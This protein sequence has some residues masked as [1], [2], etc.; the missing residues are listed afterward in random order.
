MRKLKCSITQLIPRLG[1]LF[2]AEKELIGFYL[3]RKGFNID[4]EEFAKT[5]LDTLIKED[6]LIGMLGF[7]SVENN[8]QDSDYATSVTKERRK[9]IQ[10]TKGFRFVF[11]KGSCFQNEL[12]KLDGSEN[13]EFIPVFK[14]G[15][16]L[17]AQNKD[18]SIKGFDSRLFIGIKQLQVSADVAGST[19]EVDITPRGMAAWQDS[20]VMYE[21]NEFGFD[22]IAPV[23]GLDIQVPVLVAAATTTTVRIT[24]LCADSVV[25]GLT[26]A[27]NWKMERNGVLEAVAGTVTEVNGNYTFTHAAFVAADKIRFLTY[28]TGYPVYVMDTSYYA[29]ASEIEIVA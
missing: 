14:G 13:Y 18:G 9:T 25:S 29:G 3:K 4:P 17:F 21:N 19:L 28:V 26:T 5:D 6:K 27:A 16:A 1:G 24:E 7:F 11:D 8:D 12:N 20:A 10:G 22:E 23:A 15:A 2:C